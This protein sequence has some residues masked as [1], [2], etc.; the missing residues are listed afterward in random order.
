MLIGSLL[1]IPNEHQKCGNNPSFL[2]YQTHFAKE[3]FG[4]SVGRTV[5]PKKIA[6]LVLF[7]FCLQ[8][9]PLI[10]LH[11]SFLEGFCSSS[12]QLKKNQ[13]AFT[14]TPQ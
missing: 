5:M 4:N 7:Y 9:C 1:P 12:M 14:K 2:V 3:A 8:F 10:T 6:Y 11:A 13:R